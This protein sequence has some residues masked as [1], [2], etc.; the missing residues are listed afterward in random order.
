MISFI[1]ANRHK[2][3]N[4]NIFLWI[5]NAT[6]FGCIISKIYNLSSARFKIILNAIT[7]LMITCIKYKIWFYVEYISTKEIK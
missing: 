2:Y 7:S 6:S 5:D 4:K 3:K 1:I